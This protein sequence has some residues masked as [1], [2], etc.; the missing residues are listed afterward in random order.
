MT[1]VQRLFSEPPGPTV[2]NC[3]WC[4]EPAFVCAA[5]EREGGGTPARMGLCETHHDQLLA[6]TMSEAPAEERAAYERRRNEREAELRRQRNAWQIRKAARQS[7]ARDLGRAGP[8]AWDRSARSAPPAA[9][10]GGAAQPAGA[11]APAVPQ[12]S[13]ELVAS[14]LQGERPVSPVEVVDPRL[15]D[16]A[17]TTERLREALWPLV[18]LA[19]EC[20]IFIDCNPSQTHSV[21]VVGEVPVQA[22]FRARDLLKRER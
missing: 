2:L 13:E 1:P 16:P 19:D 8:R 15:E 7:A 5:A 12:D 22:L 18:Q 10:D 9:S 21:L 6:A 17:R 11:P 14:I 20:G 4:G 3:D